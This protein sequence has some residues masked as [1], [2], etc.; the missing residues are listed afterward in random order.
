MS[1]CTFI[2]A[3]CPLDKVRPSKKYPPEIVSI[4]EQFMTV[5]PMIIS[6]CASSGTFLTIRTKSMV[7]AWNGLTI[8]KEGQD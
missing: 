2:T 5:M 3:D 6:V 8:L 7:S 1:V 4:H